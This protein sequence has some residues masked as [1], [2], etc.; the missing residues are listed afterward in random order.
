[1]GAKHTEQ[2]KKIKKI[3]QTKEALVQFLEE[4]AWN[5][6]RCGWWSQLGH[7]CSNC[8]LDSSETDEGE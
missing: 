4:Y 1:M 7:V 5:C 2:L 6:P 3:K 8:G